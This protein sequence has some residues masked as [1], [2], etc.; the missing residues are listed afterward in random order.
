MAHLTRVVAALI[1]A[2]SIFGA[3]RMIKPL[4]PTERCLD[5]RATLERQGE[6]GDQDFRPQRAYVACIGASVG[7]GGQ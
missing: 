1:V 4:T 2:G 3:A 7:R 5:L 6:A